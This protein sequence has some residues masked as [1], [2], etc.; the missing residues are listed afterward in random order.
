MKTLLVEDDPLLGQG[1]ADALA[2]QSHLVEWVT[3]GRQAISFAEST[4]FDVIILDLGLPDIDGLD[5]LKKIRTAKI[6][7]PILILTA[8]S[9]PGEKVAGLDSGADDYMIKPFDVPELM[10]R[11][12]ALQ[13]RESSQKSAF[14]CHGDIVLNPVGTAVSKKGIAVD[15]SRQEYD[16]LHHLMKRPEQTFTREALVDKLYN[17]DR[18]VESNTV[19]V[20]VHHLRKKLG[21]EIITTMRGI[22]YRLGDI[23]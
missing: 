15:L 12:R 10:A 7:T 22:G 3:T 4:E 11:L 18:N 14:I 6:T 23:H 2:Y 5:V 20:Y 1:I 17:W 9:T 8:R 19:E 21:K 13:R 16:L